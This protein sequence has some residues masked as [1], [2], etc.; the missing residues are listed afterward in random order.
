MT[1]ISGSLATHPA[2][3]FGL[4][5]AV[6]NFLTTGG[7][8]PTTA[9]PA[10]RA[11]STTTVSATMA[12]PQ[13][14]PLSSNIVVGDL[15]LMFV[16]ASMTSVSYT[17]APPGFNYIGITQNGNNHYTYVFWKIAQAGD[18]GANLSWNSGQT[19]SS[20]AAVIGSYSGVNPTL[21]FY[22]NS[23]AQ[24]SGATCNAPIITTPV[25]ST[26]VEAF[27]IYGNPGP[28]TITGPTTQRATI[29]NSVW[30]VAFSD[31][32]QG[33]AGSTGTQT[34][35]CSF[36]SSTSWVAY[37]LVLNGAVTGTGT[38]PL[39]GWTLVDS[40][41]PINTGG[42]VP[43]TTY[44]GMVFQSPSAS[45]NLGANWYL[46]F[47]LGFKTTETTF[48][49]F[50]CEIYNA[51]NHT[52]NAATH[53]TTTSGPPYAPGSGTTPPY[54][55]VAGT[56][57]SIGNVYVASYSTGGVPGAG[58]NNFLMVANK[59]GFFLSMLSGVSVVCCTYV[60]GGTTLVS[61]PSFTDPVPLFICDFTPATGGASSTREPGWTA[62]NTYWGNY[63]PGA[64]LPPTSSVNTTNLE[65]TINGAVGDFF[66]ANNLPIGW[67][68]LIA[69]NTNVSTLGTQGSV[70][71]LL[72]AW[73][74]FANQSGCVW[75][76]TV[77][78]GADTL[79]FAGVSGQASTAV[80]I[81]T[82]AA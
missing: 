23:V 54:A 65:G 74:Q 43:L 68:W 27:M 13:T 81:D 5:N 76:D 51:T 6:N 47:A 24:G 28:S 17:A 73:L 39:G 64:F 12:N 42:V 44:H 9:T 3:A 62:A 1:N 8:S 21:P 66:Q 19:G 59:D 36:G 14:I 41:R 32:T 34:A 33:A 15:I 55:Q 25:A 70:R 58:T 72:P 61:N 75:G 22:Y 11:G 45:N 78:Q 31:Q 38:P 71:G 29:A 7:V 46:V 60:G 52:Y 26:I 53:Q 79:T 50:P 56:P 18:P 40:A 69:R 48:T 35:T 82:T 20:I 80:W 63:T 49:M 30:T 4:A 77:T 37:T 57:N 67:R 16:Q 2:P 10:F